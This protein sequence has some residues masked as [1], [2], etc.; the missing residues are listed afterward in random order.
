MSFPCN[1]CQRMLPLRVGQEVRKHREWF[2]SNCGTKYDAL[3]DLESDEEIHANICWLPA[4]Q[5]NNKA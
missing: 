5:E 1:Q 3:F 4:A 2:C